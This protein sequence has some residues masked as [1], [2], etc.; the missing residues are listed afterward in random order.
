MEIPWGSIG[1]LGFLIFLS[2]YFSSSET[3]FSSVNAV[4]MQNYADEKRPGSKKA[5]AIIEN[6]DTALSAILIGNNIVNIAATSIATT[7]A[8]NLMPG[9]QGIFVSTFVMTVLVLVFGEV[10][11]KS[12]AKENAEQFCLRTS[13][14]LSFIML[15][16]KPITYIFVQLKRF[17]VSLFKTKQQTPSVTEEELKV[18]FRLGEEEGVIENHEKEL[19]DRTLDFNDIL[20]G[21]ILTPRMDVVAIDLHATNEEILATFLAERYSRLPVY[22]ENVDSI[23]GILS[24][25]DFLAAYVTKKDVKISEL[26]RDPFFVVESMKIAALLPELQKKKV[27]MAVVVDEFGGT[28]GIVTLE[29]IVEELVGEIWDEHDEKI[30]QIHQI[31]ETEWSVL[32]ETSLSDFEEQFQLTLESSEYHTVAGWIIGELQRIPTLGETLEH[33]GIQMVVSEVNERRLKKLNV[34]VLKKDEN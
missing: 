14:I 12:L 25:R 4:R 16:L 5:L 29:D 6:F 2:A 26:I 27:H 9:A 11:P 22:E 23:I 8:T 19:L 32:G 20:V 31:S 13:G 33:E 24:E 7:V 15:V 10:L 30:Q 34:N 3:A 18:M 28:S 17:V 1:F 21:E